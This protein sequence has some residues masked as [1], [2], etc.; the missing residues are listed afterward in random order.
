MSVIVRTPENKI[1]L[2]TKG[3]DNVIFER[4]TSYLG[5]TR[6][7]LD[8][9][10]SVFA[11]DG[12]RTLVL[13]RKDVEE[14]DFKSWMVEFHN[15]S[16]AVEGRSERLAEIAEKM[17]RGLVVVGATAIEDKLQE[18]VPETIAHLLEAG[19]KVWVLTGD[20]VETAINIAYSCRLLHAK[21]TLI[22]VIDPKDE[23]EGRREEAECDAALRQQLR[24]LV[25]HFEQLVEDD[26]LVGGLWASSRSD[27]GEGGWKG[28]LPWRW[29]GGRVGSQG[30]RR[31]RRRKRRRRSTALSFTT[32]PAELN[33]GAG[34]GGRGEGVAAGMLSEPL[35]GDDVDEDED[36]SSSSHMSRN[37]L[38]DVQ[39]DH[40]AL[41][42]DG[43][44]L[45]RVFG[46]WEM[47]LLLLR[48]ATLCK[49]VV[50]CRVSPA[51]KRMLIR[52]VKKG[53]K[54]PT[55]ITLAIG[56]GANDVSCWSAEA[57]GHRRTSLA[58]AIYILNNH[59]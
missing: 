40:L 42:I 4:A 57:H 15:A 23:G 54:H 31:R 52:L 38:K 11:A 21:M 9:H 34:G 59:Y 44:A 50:A 58:R 53:V 8:A 2:L 37:R 35:V 32:V 43:P 39:S 24:K 1:V 18:G 3:A 36:M 27:Q 48:V 19:I 41:I 6:Q 56:D 28:W 33:S 20:K 29:C 5:T 51:Q 26:A 30:E 7:A 10:L 14:D 22:K 12:L 47:E 55:P 46:D 17:E 49:S 25:T 45:A 13:A 16:T